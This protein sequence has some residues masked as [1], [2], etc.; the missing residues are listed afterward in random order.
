VIVPQNGPAIRFGSG[1][2]EVA[3]ALP[4]LAINANNRQRAD[5]AEL[6][7]AVLSLV[8][9]DLRQSEILLR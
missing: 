9:G 7:I 5:M 3:N 4:F 8:G 1:I 2:V 6:L